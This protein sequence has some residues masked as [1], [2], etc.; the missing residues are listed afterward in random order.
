MT[1][2]P[3]LVYVDIAA[4]QK[5]DSHYSARGNENDNPLCLACC[6]GKEAL[7]IKTVMIKWELEENGN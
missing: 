2:P 5:A 6:H 7:V 4:L 1:H 3:Y